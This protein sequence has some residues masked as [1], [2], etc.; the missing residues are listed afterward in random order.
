MSKMI[1]VRLSDERTAR[2][3]ALV[4]GGA[5]PSRSAA[6]TAAVD[7]LTAGAERR[8]IDRAIVEGYERIP[9]TAEEDAY[10]RASTR[11]S[12]AEEPW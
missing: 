10:A 7:E 1:T 12:I 11:E 8:A 6:L 9:P 5:Y 2:L 4:V 3:D